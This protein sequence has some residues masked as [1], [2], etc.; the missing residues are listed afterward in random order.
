ML[1]CRRVLINV[2][3]TL[4]LD[5]GTTYAGI[6][7]EYLY[8]LDRRLSDTNGRYCSRCTLNYMY[9]IDLDVC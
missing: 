1:D 8:S 9:L 3:C 2:F 4:Y 7:L 6:D 5:V